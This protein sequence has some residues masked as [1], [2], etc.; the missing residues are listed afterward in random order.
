MQNR[1]YTVWFI[2]VSLLLLALIAAE[3]YHVYTDM[4][5]R[6]E[7]DK[8][9]VT[10]EQLLEKQRDVVMNVFDDYQKAAYE[11]KDV[12]RITEQQLLAAE[13]QLQMLQVLAIQNAQIMELLAQ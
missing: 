11:N 3:G 10:V 6:A 8:V 9:S 2:I 12:D 7:N 5:A 4:Q 1:N 13:F